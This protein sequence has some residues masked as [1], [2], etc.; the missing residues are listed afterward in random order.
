M[1]GTKNTGPVQI[2]SDLSSLTEAELSELKSAVSDEFA[3]LDETS[4]DELTPEI[5]N[6]MSVLADA[7]DSIMQTENVRA[8][9]AAARQAARDSLR[10]RMSPAED[11]E[12]DEEA[13]TETGETD[14]DSGATREPALVASARGRTDVRDV[15]KNPRD[16]LNARLSAARRHQPADS[17]IDMKKQF[18]RSVLLASADI[19][20]FTSGGEIHNMSELVAAMQMRARSL[21]DSRA[22]SAGGDWTRVPRYPVA[23]MKREFKHMLDLS[24]TPEQAWALMQDAAN[25]QSLLAAGGWCSPSEIRYDF[26]NIAEMGGELDLPT[27]GISR[28]GMRWPTSPSFGDLADST[29]LWH[30]NE[31]QDVAAAT[32]TAQSGS[33]TCARVPCAAFSEAR[34]E[35]EGICITAGNLTTDAW[36]EQIA[37]FMRLVEVAHARRVNAWVINNLVS[38]STA[39]SICPTGIG[40]ALP[41]LDS[42]ELMV[43]DLRAKYGMNDNAIFECKMPSWVMGLIRADLARWAGIEPDKSFNISDAMIGAWFTLRGINLQLVQDW[44]VR[45]SGLFGYSSVIETWPTSFTYLIYPAGT[46]V[47]GNGLSL[48]FGVIRDSTLN[49]TNDY[50]AAWSE[51]SFLVA[52]IGHESRAVTVPVCPNGVRAAT[53]SMT[54]PVC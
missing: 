47:R 15:I 30:W 23:H 9:E 24:A 36:P 50:T 37:N 52:K 54:C 17:R 32:G 14:T 18:G 1:M 12:M 11:V 51:E 43:Q 3:K 20:G 19:A 28:G 29:G 26:Y 8:E 10:T 33:K 48:D 27:T 42:V 16:G 41:L 25:P 38:Q 13:S 4:D 6:R 5:L 39:V 7:T 40:A 22:F 49:A 35:F 45:T 34:L 44:Q 46:F 2:P 53:A 21:P 31:T